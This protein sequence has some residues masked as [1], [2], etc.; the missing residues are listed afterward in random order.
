MDLRDFMFPFW[1]ILFRKLQV[2]PLPLTMVGVR[3]GERLLQIGIDDPATV[4]ALAK[5][6]GLS[7]VNALAAPDDATARRADAAA[8]AGGVLIDVQVTN[9]RLFPFEA[10][11]FDVVVVHGARGLLASLRPEDRVACLQEARRMLRPGGRLVVIESA[12]RGGLAGL[13]RAHA[14]SEPYA[15]RGGAEGALKAEGFRP[16]RVLGEIE[17]YIFTEGLKT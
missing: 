2:E 4:G 12:P 3:M 5:K 17:G 16:V 15:K 10:G 6:V 1:R 13:V 9:W 8:A 7:G 11:S 14:V